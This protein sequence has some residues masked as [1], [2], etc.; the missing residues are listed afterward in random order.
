M[1]PRLLNLPFP[2]LLKGRYPSWEWYQ[3]MGLTIQHSK[4]SKRSSH[5]GNI[6][7]VLSE[8]YFCPTNF[9]HWGSLREALLA[10]S[11]TELIQ[12]T[13]QVFHFMITFLG[14]WVCLSAATPWCD[15]NPASK[16]WLLTTASKSASTFPSG[17]WEQ[18]QGCST[19]GASPSPSFHP[20][21]STLGNT[22][23]KQQSKKKVQRIF[24]M[25]IMY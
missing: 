21:G 13:Y 17:S 7:Q 1:M 25:F 22:I 24:Q 9:G 10:V 4:L 19:S 15:S 11:G 14:S 20:A 18:V 5:C 23:S 6:T 8:H 12:G 16:S 2:K 3:L